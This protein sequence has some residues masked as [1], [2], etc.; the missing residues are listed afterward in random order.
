MHGKASAGPDAIRQSKAGRNVIA[1][2]ETAVRLERS[3]LMDAS[4]RKCRIELLWIPVPGHSK[5][6]I[7]RG[8]T[9]E[10]ESSQ[11]FH[12]RQQS[13]IADGVEIADS[14]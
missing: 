11:R 9:D 14:K 7:R 6:R 12:A 10:K 13:Q 3:E 1:G 8:P 4:L 2:H 5:E